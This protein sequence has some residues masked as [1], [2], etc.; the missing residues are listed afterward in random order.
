MLIFTGCVLTALSA[1]W[2]LR[3]AMGPAMARFPQ[4]GW[5]GLAA[6]AG[7]EAALA[8]RVPGV[9]CFFT[10]WIWTAYIVAVDAAVYRRRGDS[11]LRRPAAFTAMAALSVPAWVIF[12][13][14]NLRLR[15]W[16]YVGLPGHFW[17]V[18]AGA[19]WAFATIF[20]GIFETADLIACGATGRRRCRG[21]TP[22]RLAAPAL[23]GLALLAVPVALPARA[24]AYLFALVWAGFILLDPLHRRWGWPSLLADLE[25]GWAG[26]ALALLAAGAV[27]GFLWEF[28]NYWARSRWQYVFPILLRFRIFAMP[29]PGFIGFPPFALECFTLYVLLSQTLLPPHLRLPLLEPPPS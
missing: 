20:P 23:L 19:T 24:G 11:M 4:Y 15:N 17:V 9:T 28:W 3:L 18:A 29:V 22:P 1:L 6:M 5:W 21:W 8:L 27:C 16:A 12:E 7:L 13:V 2:L 25:A 10:A 26:R 14:Y